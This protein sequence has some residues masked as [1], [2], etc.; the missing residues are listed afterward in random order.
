MNSSDTQ[1]TALDINPGETWLT[2]GGMHAT[3][4]AVNGGGGFPIHGAVATPCG[5]RVRAWTAEGCLVG[6]IH[7]AQDD[8]KRRYDWRQELA[9]IWAVLEP[10]WRWVG[11]NATRQWYLYCVQPVRGSAGFRSMLGVQVSLAHMHMPDPACE[12]FDTLTERPD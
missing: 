9:P 10:E 7:R 8:L 4:Y 1:A 6:A 2:Y 3:I 5:P 11:R 12:W